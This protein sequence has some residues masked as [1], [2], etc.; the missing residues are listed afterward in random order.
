MKLEITKLLYYYDIPT[1]FICEDINQNDYIFTLFT[2]VEYIGLKVSD[3]QK[4]LFLNGKIDLRT[5]FV[6]NNTDFLIGAFINNEEI[7]VVKYTGEI[8][9]DILP[10]YGLIYREK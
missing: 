3:E 8:N 7:E 4:M 6:K 2:D 9:D 1:L 10:D 5:I